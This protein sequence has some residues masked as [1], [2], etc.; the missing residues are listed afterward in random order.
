[1]CPPNGPVLTVS[2]THVHTCVCTV[3]YTRSRVTSSHSDELALQEKRKVLFC[4]ICRFHGVNT[5]T[6]DEV[7]PVTQVPEHATGS[8]P[9]HS[10]R[11]YERDSLSELADVHISIIG[12]CWKV[13]WDTEFWWVDISP[14]ALRLRE[15]RS[16]FWL[17]RWGDQRPLLLGAGEGNDRGWDGW[18]VSLTWWR[19]VWASSRS[20]WWTG[21]PG[22]LQSMGSQ[23]VGHD[24]VTEWQ[25]RSKKASWK[26]VGHGWE[27]GRDQ[28]WEG[29][30]QT[31]GTMKSKGT[32]ARMQRCLW[33]S[34]ET[35]TEHGRE[36]RVG[37]S[38]LK[39][40]WKAVPFWFCR[41]RP[42]GRFSSGELPGSDLW[43]GRKKEKSGFPTFWTVKNRDLAN[44]KQRHCS[45]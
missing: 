39:G 24:W 5:F 42:C 30:F 10:E 44:T 38:C 21:R 40:F 32:E 18:M 26:Q 29:K 14:K 34:R 20:W 6:L 2:N 43:I 41:H 7:K 1:M 25:Q 8:T 28:G 37:V 23:I 35:I 33:G 13:Q 19:W 4:S 31:R 12:F 16:S 36:D 22:V 11:V 27:E 17:C 9:F 15:M 3:T 45:E